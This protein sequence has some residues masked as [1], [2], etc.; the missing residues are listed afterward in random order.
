MH[1]MILF[2][3][4][5][6]FLVAVS[7]R[8]LLHPRS[9]GFP[10]FFAWEILLTMLV[11]NV[12]TWF[13][14]PFMWHQLLSW[15]L[16]I[17]SLALVILGLSLLRQIGEQDAGRKDA[18]LLALEKTSKLVRVGLYRYIRHPLYSSLLFLG[19]GM[20]FKSPSWLDAVLVVL[21]TFFLTATARTEERENMA[22]FGSEYVDYMK[23]T[24]RF[25]PFLF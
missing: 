10:R 13:R 14:N 24:R 4:G 19:W 7:R 17:I 5:T 3:L 12:E 21:C 9:H 20:F 16:L 6:F 23:H 8:S 22:Y 18:S 25:I 1:K 11:L 2:V 15:T